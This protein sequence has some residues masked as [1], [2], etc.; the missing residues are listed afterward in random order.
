MD[1]ASKNGANLVH[2]VSKPAMVVY[3]DNIKVKFCSFF[4]KMYV[5]G[6]H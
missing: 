1:I 6:T 4:I 3:G 5:V 2:E